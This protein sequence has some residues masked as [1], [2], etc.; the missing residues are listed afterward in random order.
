MGV[1]YNS[2]TVVPAQAKFTGTDVLGTGYV[3]AHDVALTDGTEGYSVAKP[4]TANLA[5]PFMVVSPDSDGKQGPC[6]VEGYRPGSVA[7]VYTKAACVKG[8]TK[9]KLVNGQYYLQAATLSSASVIATPTNSI[10]GD[11]YFATALETLDT[12]TT[13]GLVLCVI[14]PGLGRA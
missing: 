3:L 1:T 12:S 6:L 4:A 11:E 5:V 2:E 14:G 8:V 7:R 13:A 10:V 9:L